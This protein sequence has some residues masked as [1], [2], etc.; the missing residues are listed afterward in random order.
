MTQL[1]TISRELTL[2]LERVWA[3]ERS[4][5]TTGNMN[6]P[7]NPLGAGLLRL[8]NAVATR[9]ANAPGDPWLNRT[10]NL[11]HEE[12]PHLDDLFAFYREAGARGHLELCPATASDELM[13]SLAERGAHQVGF[14]TVTYGLPT[15]SVPAPAPGVE[16]HEIG[17]EELDTFLEV[18]QR[19][20]GLP[21]EYAP[22]FR[23]WY[24]LA[25]WRLYLATVDGAPAG[26]AILVMADGV[27]YM[28]SGATV[29]EAR[30]RGVQK[31]MLYQRIADAARAG[32]EIL[33]GQCAFGSISHH[34]QEVC[35]LRTAYT[36]AVWI[37]PAWA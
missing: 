15:R 11:T 31:A 36:K 8:G 27:G 14:H 23:F 20:F 9:A 28:A 6:R 10:A 13:R 29:P 17:R 16:V 25:G 18:N 1:P 12:I 37:T 32:C 2:R 35:G 19:G 26:A 4:A 3:Y 30:G 5:R 22:L 7:G 34:N 21:V 33:F 24:D